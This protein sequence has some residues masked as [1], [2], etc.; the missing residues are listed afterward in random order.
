VSIE[1]GQSWSR[2]SGL[3]HFVLNNSP[4]SRRLLFGRAA[5]EM[6]DPDSTLSSF[7]FWLQGLSQHDQSLDEAHTSF[8]YGASRAMRGTVG[9]DAVFTLHKSVSLLAGGQAAAESVDAPFINRTADDSTQT[10][11]GFYGGVK[12]SPTKF[13]DFVVSGRGDRSPISTN[14]EYSYRAS[15]ICYGD[16]WSL[17]LTGASAFRNP[18]YVEAVGL[19]I[20]PVS[21]FILLEGT[22]TI[23]SP[24]NTSVELGANFSP[25]DTLTLS[26]TLYLS[27]LSNLMVEDF[28]SVLRRTFRNDTASRNIVGGEL[29]ANWRVSD[30]LA[31]L[32]SL[33][34]LHWLHSD[35]PSRSNVGV[36]EQNSKFLGGL[37]LQGLFGKE[38]WGYGVGATVASPR[39]YNVRTGI[40]P[41]VLTREIPTTARLTAMIEHQLVTSPA[42]W[43]SLRLGASLPGDT[44]E[45]PI[46][47]SAPLGQ[48]AILGV[49]IRRE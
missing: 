44:A 41:V 17:R 29:E 14:M 49:E 46:P 6:A 34:V 20:D 8:S 45:S 28:E 3:D 43:T 24:R 40:P 26:P 16:T 12:A 38:R 2:R 25:I 13:L 1:A 4:Q 37:R 15:V 33:T 7:K 23:H 9:T 31:V 5:Y 10:S 19:F 21:R 47:A 22:S 39:T 27:K 48:S 42:I 11:V 18:T 35:D 32:P 30:S 36:P